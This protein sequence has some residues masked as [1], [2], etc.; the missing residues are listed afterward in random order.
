MA[1]IEGIKKRSNLKELHEN[2]VSEALTLLRSSL[3]HQNVEIE[4]ICEDF[5]TVK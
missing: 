1:K 3:S 5:R 4:E 2:A